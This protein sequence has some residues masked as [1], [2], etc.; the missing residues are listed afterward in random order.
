[1]FQPTEPQI[2]P[3]AACIAALTELIDTGNALDA[4]KIMLWKNN[5]V[6]TINTVLADLVVADFAGYANFGP[7]VWGTVYLDTDKSAMVTGG[8]HEFVASGPTPENVIYGWA[9]VNTGVTL[10]LK[11]ARFDNPVAI[12]GTGAACVVVPWY[13]YAG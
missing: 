9:I 13:R 8:S 4:V 12:F 7:V 10:L 2:V 1:M 6:P 3:S 11:A 5:V